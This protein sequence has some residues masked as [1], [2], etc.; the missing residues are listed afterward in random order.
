MA[1]PSVRLV[2]VDPY[3]LAPRAA[4]CPLCFAAAR[5]PCRSLVSGK[6]LHLSHL[7]RVRVAVVVERAVVPERA[8]LSGN[9][10]DRRV[11]RRRGLLGS[12]QRVARGA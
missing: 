1:D 12:L 6:K 5:T 2:D 8:G 7:A 10:H 9:A 4:R 11:A 3:R